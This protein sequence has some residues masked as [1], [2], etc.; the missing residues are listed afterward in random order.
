MSW[1]AVQ[2]LGSAITT[3]A[4]GPGL[5]GTTDAVLMRGLRRKLAGRYDIFIAR[6]TVEELTTTPSCRSRSGL[7]WVI[8]SWCGRSSPTW[9]TSWTRGAAG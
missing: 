2:L 8:A 3:A 1:L 9:S 7:A 5:I 6:K 4:G